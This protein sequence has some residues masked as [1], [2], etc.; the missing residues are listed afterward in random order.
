[1]AQEGGKQLL[2][3][4]QP[5]TQEPVQPVMCRLCRGK[6]ETED[7]QGC[8]ACK[9]Q[10]QMDPSDID[11]WTFADLDEDLG[12]GAMGAQRMKT[13]HVPPGATWHTWTEDDGRGY[14]WAELRV[15]AGSTEVRERR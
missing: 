10:G 11:Q 4:E 1:M 2:S 14:M 5:S 6:G 8:V 13:L 12:P 7:E 9:G 3:E 15:P